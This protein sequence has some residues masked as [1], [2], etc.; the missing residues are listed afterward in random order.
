MKT[1]GK[2]KRGD[3]KR[4]LHEHNQLSCCRYTIMPRMNYLHIYK[5]TP[6]V[7]CFVIYRFI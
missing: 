3:E 1:G 7:S 5:W 4:N 6:F 2:K